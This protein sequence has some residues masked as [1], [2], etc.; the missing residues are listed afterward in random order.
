MGV[1]LIKRTGRDWHE[2]VETAHD[3]VA[4]L[5]AELAEHGMI[6]GSYLWTEKIGPRLFRVIKRDGIIITKAGL[7]WATEP[8]VRFEEAV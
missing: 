6:L 5:H 7:E 1:F 2:N 4:D 3:C 8:T